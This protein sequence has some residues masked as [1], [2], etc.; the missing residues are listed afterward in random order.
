LFTYL[1]C[2]RILD[3]KLREDKI[4][5]KFYAINQYIKSDE[6]RVVDEKGEQVGVITRDDALSRAR[7]AGLDLVLVAPN[8]KPPVAKIVSFAKFKYEQKQK[9]ASGKKKSKSVDIKEIRFTPFIA[10]GDFN[11][12]IKKA[13][14]FLESG[15]KVRL[16]V[17]FVGRQ[18]T[19]KDFGDRI[20]N[21]AMDE[22]DEISSVEFH[23][24]LNGKLL[25][26]QLQP[27]KSNKK[28]NEAK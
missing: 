13:K 1:K 18:I 4:A 7:T 15:D 9:D 8:T 2:D 21:K 23:P 10:E 22:L 26:T 3:L 12:R 24:R 6:L 27:I 16:T 28:K 25:F 19:R 17:K 5:K 14:K 20:I 11:Q